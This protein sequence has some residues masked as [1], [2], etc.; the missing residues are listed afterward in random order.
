MGDY[1]VST[2]CPDC[3]R[4]IT[5][6]SS[7]WLGELKNKGTQEKINELAR[8]ACNCQSNKKEAG[9]GQ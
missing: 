1:S 8:K 2:I 4:R 7:E 9:G 5:V 6:Y 3:G